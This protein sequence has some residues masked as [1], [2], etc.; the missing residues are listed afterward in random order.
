MAPRQSGWLYFERAA[1]P[2]S[3]SSR[4]LIRW[5][6]RLL[7]EPKLLLDRQQ[8]VEDPI[9]VLAFKAALLTRGGSTSS[10]GRRILAVDMVITEPSGES[11]CRAAPAPPFSA[12]P[13]RVGAMTCAAKSKSSE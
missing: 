7:D 13:R 6:L 9:T 1:S 11:R 10:R 2:H 4:R 3:S 8:P 5:R 12:P